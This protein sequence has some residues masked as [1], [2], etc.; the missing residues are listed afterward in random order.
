MNKR[1]LY[2]MESCR[3]ATQ[4]DSE[5]VRMEGGGEI[6]QLL[7]ITYYGHRAIYLSKFFF[8]FFASPCG[9]Q[10]PPPRGIELVPPAVEAWSF[11]HWTTREVQCCI[12]LKVEK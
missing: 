2:I 1:S 11:N 4:L 10:D 5:R 7:Q 9:M 8:F 12:F 6:C 3:E